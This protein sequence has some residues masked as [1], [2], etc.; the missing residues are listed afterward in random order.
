MFKECGVGLVLCLGLG[1][2]RT[3][4]GPRCRWGNVG[5]VHL[6]HYLGIT[7]GDIAMNICQP[8]DFGG[9]LSLEINVVQVHLACLMCGGVPRDTPKEHILRN[10]AEL[11]DQS[12]EMCLELGL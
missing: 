4:V 2:T 5:I 7:L 11:F 6:Y 1:H 10:V 3:L 12:L 8:C 9:D